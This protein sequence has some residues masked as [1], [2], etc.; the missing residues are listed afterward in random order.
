MLKWPL[1]PAAFVFRNALLLLFPF[2][3]SSF[4]AL[5]LSAVFPTPV[6]KM[7]E[8]RISREFENQA[9]KEKSKGLPVAPFMKNLSDPILRNQV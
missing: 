1:I 7:W 5:L 9:T 4:L 8:E 2:K 6:A 3:F